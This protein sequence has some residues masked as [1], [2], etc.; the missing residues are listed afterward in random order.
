MKAGHER[1]INRTAANVVA[2]GD[3]FA[4]QDHEL[5]VD[6]DF[7]LPML[8]IDDEMRSRPNFRDLTGLR[9]GRLQVLCVAAGFN[10]RWVC[11]CFCGRYTRRHKKFL[12]KEQPEKTQTV[13]NQCKLLAKAKSDDLFRR[14]GK[15]ID[16][17]EFL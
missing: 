1:P 12:V 4:Y 8:V 13:C 17:D 16:K 11:R 10:G 14:T 15:R 5:C 9:V 2:R 7:P 6:S 3:S